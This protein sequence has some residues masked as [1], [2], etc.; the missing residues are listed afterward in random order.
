MIFAKPSTG[1]ERVRSSWLTVD[2]NALLAASASSAI[3][4]RFLVLLEET[5]DFVHVL[6]ELTVGVGVVQRDA[7]MTPCFCITFRWSAPCTRFLA[8]AQME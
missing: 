5:A 3:E 2:R 4:S 7:C 6:V 8:E 1:G